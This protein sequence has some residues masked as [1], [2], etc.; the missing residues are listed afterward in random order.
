M[1]N[2]IGHKNRNQIRNKKGGYVGLVAL[3]VT[4]AIIAILF[5]RQYTSPT[6]TKS[7]IQQDTQAIN[8]AQAV[9]NIVEKQSQDTQD[10]ANQMGN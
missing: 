8:Q 10:A 2:K 7:V 9:K 5:A 3:L 4:V 6:G 1:K